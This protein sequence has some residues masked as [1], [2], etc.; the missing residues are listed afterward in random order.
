[1]V[2]G[3][4][5]P[6]LCIALL[7]LESTLKGFFAPTLTSLSISDKENLCDAFCCIQA[8]RRK[9]RIKLLSSCQASN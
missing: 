6:M 5:S 7:S 8:A 4:F 3:G 2:C 9:Q 1:M